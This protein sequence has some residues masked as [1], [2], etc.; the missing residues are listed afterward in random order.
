MTH[1]DITSWLA[2]RLVPD[3]DLDRPI[4]ARLAAS[5]GEQESLWRHCV[6]FNTTERHY[7]QLYRDPNIDVWVIC[8]ADT[9]DTGYHDHDRSQGAVYVCEGA[10]FEDF[11]H[12][13]TDGWIREKTNRHDVA[14][15]FDFD[16][17]YI[18]GVRYAAGEP[19]VSVHC[20]SPALWR[21]GHYEPD[22]NGVLRRVST[23]YADELL[24]VA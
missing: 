19:A 23:T 10:L 11:F 7:T 22:D 6:Q 5:I 24:G 18:H 1:T 16:A 13:D 15:S 8:W 2:G 9:Q 20:Y 3:A 12:R 17:T 14:G 4:L 21:M